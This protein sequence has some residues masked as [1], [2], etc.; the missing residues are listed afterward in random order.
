MKKTKSM[1]KRSIRN[2]LLFATFLILAI[3]L[4]IAIVPYAYAQ[5]SGQM[6]SFAY[7]AVEPNPV[8]VGQTTYV[9]MWIDGPLAD[10]SESNNIRRHDYKLTITAPDGT[11]TTKTWDVIADT[12]G[13]QSTS[14][15]PTM[16][17]T[18]TFQFSYPGQTY[19]WNATAAQQAAYGLKV[20]GANATTTLTVQQDIVS[21]TQNSPLPTEYW[22]RP[23]YG[24]DFNWYVLGSQWLGGNYLG[25]FQQGSLNLWQTGG[26]GPDSPHIMWTSP[27]ES[28][29]V[30]GGINTGID[31]ATYYSG[32][33]YEGRFQNA[34]IMDGK[35][36]YKLPLS[37]Q[38]SATEVG[39]GAYVCQD[40]R[41]GEIIWTNDNINPTFGELYTYESP[42]QHGTVPNGY[43]W[44]TVTQSSTTQTWIAIDPKTGRWLFNLTDVPSTGT[45]AYTNQGEIV[46]Y[47]LN[48]NT[49][50]KTGW[51][52]LWNW[53]SANGVPANSTTANGVQL[54]GPGSGTNYLQFRPVGRVINT[55]TAYSWNVSITADLTGGAAPAITYVIPGDIILGTSYTSGIIARRGVSNPYT[56]WALSL[57]DSSKGT[58]VWKKSYDAP[59]NNA[60]R[61]MGPLDPV[62]RVFTMTDGETM[63]WLGYN[64]DNGNLLWGPTTTPLRTFQ[65]FGSGGGPGQKAVTAY[66]NL[67][68]QGYGGELFCYNSLDGKLL[69]KFNDTDSGVDTS[70]GLMP[71]FIA[72]IADGKVY[73]FNNEHSPNSPLYKGY[74]IY[75]LNATTG[76]EIYKMLSWSGQTGGGGGNTAVL[77]DNSLVYY[78]YYDNQLYCISKGPTQTTVSAP[79]LAAASGQS[80]VIS[81][82]V[83]DLSAGTNQNEQAARF[84]NGV[85]AASDKSTPAWMEYV[86][87]DQPYPTNFTGVNVVLNIIDAN[88]NYRTIGTATTDSSG[89]YGYTWVP[90]ITGQYTVVATF[91]GNKGYYGSYAEAYFAVDQATATTT[92]QPVQTPSFADQYL[93]PISIAIM[94]LI[95]IVGAVIVLAIRKRP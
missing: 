57:Q 8:G 78:N 12:T 59:S 29:G 58:L 7:I 11:V 40:L 77:A 88:G 63:V 52:A 30:V 70:W 14:F 33:S 22:T 61:T 24:E 28:G 46:K 50:K 64:L 21:P 93:L 53:T 94:V 56:L 65:Y 82:K 84:P 39:G 36:Y 87:M 74:S 27:I 45:I 44:Q 16:T 4:N 75:C 68:V 55:S 6:G 19:T 85:A 9:A 10:A 62:N 79:N 26:V 18:Y 86:Y 41:T 13:V 81:G 76:E 54:N 66:G 60:T 25:T 83:I 51:L 1:S 90:D 71:I 32:G 3:T 49:A 80:V 31:G 17:G 34:I 47:I 42:N 91:T 89:S 67:Y 73:A 95:I 20:L 72:A 23:I 37:D 35:L 48:Y 5:S 15:T 43:L 69:W 2:P 38:A 92:P